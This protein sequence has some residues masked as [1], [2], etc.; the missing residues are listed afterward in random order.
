MHVRYKEVED[1]RHAIKGYPPSPPKKKKENF[2][3]FSYLRTRALAN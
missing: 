3:L 1:H 2:T